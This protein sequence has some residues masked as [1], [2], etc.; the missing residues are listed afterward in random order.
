[1]FSLLFRYESF[2]H[3]QSSTDHSGGTFRACPYRGSPAC[4]EADDGHAD[5]SFRSDYT[6]VI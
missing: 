6:Q 2:T 3:P 4:G 1:M 5:S